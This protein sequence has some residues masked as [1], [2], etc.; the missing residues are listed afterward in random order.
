MARPVAPRGEARARVLEAALDLFTTQ[1]VNG[2]SLQ[3]IADR[4][5]VTKA[6]VYFQFRTKEDILR[7][8]IAPAFGRITDLVARAQAEPD[9]RQRRE[10]AIRGLV[11]L[12]VDHRRGAAL[13]HTDP[14]AHAFLETH[15]PFQEPIRALARMLGGDEAVGRVRFACFAGGAMLCGVNPELRDVDEPTLRQALVDIGLRLLLD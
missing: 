8:L 3:M 12:V 11:D 7:A 13:L 10:L 5:G 6:A 4:I 9:P 14:A 1:G 15:R 2:T